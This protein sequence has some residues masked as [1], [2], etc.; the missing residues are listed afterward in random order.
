MPPLTLDGTTG[1]SAVQAGAVESGDLAAG[2][3][4]SGDLPAGTVLQMQSFRKDGTSSQ[5]IGGFTRAQVS[6]VGV[7]ITPFR[8]NSTMLIE[9]SMFFEN[10]P[11]QLF[12]LMFSID[13][14]GVDIGA[15]SAGSRNT[16]IATGTRG[17]DGSNADSTPNHLSMIVTDQ[18]NTTSNISYI[19]TARPEN[20]QSI[21]VNR[22]VSDS[23]SPNQERGVT[24]ITVMEIAG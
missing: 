8:S 7:S 18:P 24:T 9:V 15:P 12:N 14:N 21:F 19:L 6:N 17:F 13:R 2:A 23:D 1:V 20:S 3:I 10:D 5:S 22:N 4:G 16:G 11:D